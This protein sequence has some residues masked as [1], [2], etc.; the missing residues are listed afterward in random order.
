VPL[1]S[2][3]KRLGHSNVHVTA[4]VYSHA[5]PADEIAAAEIW[6]TAMDRAVEKNAPPAKRRQVL[7][8]SSKPKS[9]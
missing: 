4:T 5:L 7:P 1:P 2:V 6:Q 3:S 8:M 9:A